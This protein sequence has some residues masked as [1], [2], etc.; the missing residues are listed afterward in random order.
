[1]LPWSIVFFPFFLVLG[2]L[3]GIV[4]I[5]LLCE[6]EEI[7]PVVLLLGLITV[8]VFVSFGFYISASR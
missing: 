5:K 1:M 3:L 7:A 8:L 2:P 4:A 6:F